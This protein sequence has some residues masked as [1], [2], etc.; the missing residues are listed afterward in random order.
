MCELDFTEDMCYD[1]CMTMIKE[2]HNGTAPGRAVHLIDAE[3]LVGSAS[4]ACSEAEL[5]YAAYEQV[6]ALR[7]GDLLIVA[8]SHHA[9]PAA[10]FGFPVSARRLVRSGL[11]GA[12]QALLDV[13]AFESIEA[14]FDR[15]VIGSGDGIFALPAAQLQASGC[16]V[17]VVARRF[18]LSRKLRLAVRDVRFIDAPPAAAPA[19]IP[20]RRAA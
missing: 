19:I 3:N 17:S 9:A 16:T 14:R 1:V 4:F 10:W 18:S 12:D 20:V 8:T 15:V 11:H 13:I 7:S 5:A 6:A 2:H